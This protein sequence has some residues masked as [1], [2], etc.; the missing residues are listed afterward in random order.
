MTAVQPG[1]D[2][3]ARAESG[4]IVAIGYVYRLQGFGAFFLFGPE[5]R[6]CPGGHGLR[7]L[8]RLGAWALGACAMSPVTSSA[9]TG[10]EDSSPEA[11]ILR[12][13]GASRGVSALWFPAGYPL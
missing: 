9:T 6:R 2:R 13:A 1:A 7:A 8:G 5:R 12:P 11:A 4:R 10:S 3:L